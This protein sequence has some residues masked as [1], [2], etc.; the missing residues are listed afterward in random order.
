MSVNYNTVL[1]ANRRIWQEQLAKQIITSPGLHVIHIDA[2]QISIGG[3]WVMGRDDLVRLSKQYPDQVFEVSFSADD[4]ND[5]LVATY[6]YLNGSWKFISE[7]YE[8]CFFIPCSDLDKLD[9]QLYNRFKEK[10]TAYFSQI[11]NYR[12]RTSEDDPSFCAFPVKISEE[13]ESLI[14]SVEYREGDAILRVSKYG[15]TFMDVKVKFKENSPRSSLEV[16]SS[17]EGLA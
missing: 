7:K 8:Y 11:D 6:H 17:S 16:G 2:D 10:V 9:P 5:Y 12:I 4:P 15:L 1:K 13:Q 3:N 14:P